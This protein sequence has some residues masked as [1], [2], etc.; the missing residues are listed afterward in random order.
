M[1]TK[2]SN[3]SRNP[4]CY[5]ECGVVSIRSVSGIL[6]PLLL[7]FDLVSW[8]LNQG[9][10]DAAPT[11]SRTPETN[12]SAATTGHASGSQLYKLDKTPRGGVAPKGKWG[13]ELQF[14][15]GTSRDTNYAL[16]RFGIILITFLNTCVALP[17][18]FVP[19][20]DPILII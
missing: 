3:L 16:S 11:M 7:P 2:L 6:Q 19:K 4:P 15:S 9:F 17:K 10:D 13:R 1:V 12:N 8:R 18:R 20:S 14:R 5:V